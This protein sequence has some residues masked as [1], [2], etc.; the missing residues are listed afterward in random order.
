MR[1]RCGTCG[2]A[3]VYL[4]YA[5]PLVSAKRDWKAHN[6]HHENC[7]L[8]LYN[9]TRLYL[10]SLRATFGMEVGHPR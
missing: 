10:S 1:G 9:A 7:H 8:L 5:F 3:G 2:I 4:S 6:V